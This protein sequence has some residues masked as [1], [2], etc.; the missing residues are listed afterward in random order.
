[1]HELARV[2]QEYN[3]FG[4]RRES[5]YGNTLADAWGN[6]KKQAFTLEEEDGRTSRKLAEEQYLLR[7]P[8][9]RSF[10]NQVT[11]WR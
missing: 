4:K 10:Q 6:A 8:E 9:T 7:E 2:G 11:G 1:V 3:R 5:C